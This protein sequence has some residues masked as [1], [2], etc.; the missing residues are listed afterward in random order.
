MICIAHCYKCKWM[1]KCKH[2]FTIYPPRLLNFVK[3]SNRVRFFCRP[4]HKAWL[5][6]IFKTYSD[7]NKRPITLFYPC[8][9]KNSPREMYYILYVYRWQTTGTPRAEVQ[10]EW[11]SAKPFWHSLY[12]CLSILIYYLTLLGYNNR[13]QSMRIMRLGVSSRG[14]SITFDTTRDVK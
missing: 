1:H 13:W 7:Y 10:K 11:G 6:H 4:Q 9:I 14:I 8:R 5:Q 2:K 12:S 3:F